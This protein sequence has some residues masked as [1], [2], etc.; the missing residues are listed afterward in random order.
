MARNIKFPQYFNWNINKFHISNLTCSLLLDTLSVIS[1]GT[2]SQS[3]KFCFSTQ[4]SRFWPNWSIWLWLISRNI[5]F[6]QFLSDS[7]GI[8][9]K[10]LC[11]K[12]KTRKN[13]R[14][15]KQS[16]YSKREN[17]IH[18]LNTQNSL[19]VS[20]LYNKKINKNFDW[21]HIKEKRMN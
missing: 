1:F 15:E 7:R 6:G 13:V 5:R 14:L 19:S 18:L 9:A 16:S 11:R 17:K 12:F 21:Y 8:D 10:L 3:F 4:K 2:T 20:D